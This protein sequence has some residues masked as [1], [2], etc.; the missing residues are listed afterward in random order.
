MPTNDKIH[1]AW[2]HDVLM[3]SEFNRCMLDMI[4]WDIST[5]A[6][7]HLVSPGGWAGCGSGPNLSGARNRV[8]ANFLDNTAA[9][10]LLSVDTD[11]V[12]PP[13]MHHQLLMSASA[14]GA[15]VMGALYWGIKDENNGVFPQMWLWDEDGRVGY[16]DPIPDTAVKVGATGAGFVLMH[17]TALEDVR[18]TGFNATFPWYQETDR[19]DRHVSEDIELCYR[20]AEA[21]HDVWVDP[22]LE[23]GHLKEIPLH[24]ETLEPG[25]F[26]RMGIA[27][28]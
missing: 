25:A 9:D 1:I 5:N 19:N 4:A 14:V 12:F 21:G 2:V 13:W 23:V 28:R 24:R 7:H 20:L 8:V 11:M 6:A 3:H 16:P 10:W 22:R 18:S 17:R 15:T 27:A 26:L